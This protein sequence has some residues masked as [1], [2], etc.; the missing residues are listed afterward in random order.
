MSV[1]RAITNLHTGGMTVA[2]S[3]DAF[4]P[5]LAADKV[6]RYAFQIAETGFDPQ[7][8]GDLYST[9]VL[10]AIF[11]AP[12]RY[13]HLARPHRIVANTAAA[14]PE[15]VAD[16]KTGLLVPPRDPEAFTVV[17]D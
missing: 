12:Y 10:R 15:I 16:G 6:F 11:E 17:L 4:A 5:A 14:L 8:A 2:E 13:D 7:A 9:H 3:L 1:R